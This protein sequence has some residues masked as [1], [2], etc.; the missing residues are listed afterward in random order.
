VTILNAAA[1]L[2]VSGIVDG[3]ETGIK[4]AIHSIDSGAALDKLNQM[5]KISSKLN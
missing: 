5:I 3:L 4:K 2:K 1:A